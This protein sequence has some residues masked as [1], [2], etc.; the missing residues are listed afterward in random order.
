MKCFYSLLL[1]LVIVQSTSFAADIDLHVSHGRSDKGILL[2]WK[3]QELI[4][5]VILRSEQKN[6]QFIEIAR[7]NSSSYE[8]ISCVP[9]VEYFY[10]VVPSTSLRTVSSIQPLSG[11]KKIELGGRYSIDGELAKKNQPRPSDESSLD[12]SRLSVLERE[13]M[14][15]LEIRFFFFVT[16]PYVNKGSVIVLTDFDEFYASEESNTVTFTPADQS[17]QLNFVSS[18]PFQLLRRTQDRELF[19]RLLR[20]GLALCIYQGEIKIKDRLGR[21]KYVPKLEAI[22]FFTQY[23]KYART[24]S[25]ST[26]LYSTEHEELVKKMKQVRD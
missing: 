18:A 2:T 24:W 21:N 13:Y 16:N 8:D 22:G 19:N 12:V 23:H 26:I 17:Y 10:K 9:G 20:N 14:S 7:S 3:Q 11:Y 15:W 4:I 1:L 5:Y 25:T 6:G